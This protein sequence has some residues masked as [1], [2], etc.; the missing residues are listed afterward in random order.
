MFYKFSSFIRNK[1]FISFNSMSK[2][3]QYW[4]AVPKPANS[5]LILSSAETPDRLI[6]IGDVHGCLDELQELLLKCNYDYRDKNILENKK[7][8]QVLLLGDLVNKGPYS[9]EVLR[10]VRESGFLCIRG[11]HDDAALVHALGL[12]PDPHPTYQDYLHKLNPSVN[13]TFSFIFHYIN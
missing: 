7:Q 6:V 5:H 3:F 11:N 2:N 10:F 9:A 4:N 12:T 8:Q 1:R 13:I